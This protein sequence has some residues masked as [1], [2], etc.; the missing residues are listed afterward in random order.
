MTLENYKLDYWKQFKNSQIRMNVIK[1]VIKT[2]DKI[3]QPLLY[4]ESIHI[5][6]FKITNLIIAKFQ[7]FDEM[8]FLLY[9]V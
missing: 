2:L 4:N 9:Y 1:F 8:Q 6:F 7:R 5:D 3:A